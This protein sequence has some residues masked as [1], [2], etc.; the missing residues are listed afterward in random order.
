MILYNDD[1]INGSVEIH[2]LDGVVSA[3]VVLKSGDNSKTLHLEQRTDAWHVASSFDN[4][5]ESGIYTVSLKVTD[6]KG[7]VTTFDNIET[8]E[9]RLDNK[10]NIDFTGSLPDTV[11]VGD[12]VTAFFNANDDVGLEKVTV[13]VNTPG[14]TKEIPLLGSGV[15]K[16]VYSP[17]QEGQYTFTVEVTD[18]RGQTTTKALGNFEV[19]IDTPPKIIDYIIPKQAYKYSNFDILANV[20]DDLG[21]TGIRISFL[22]LGRLL[23]EF[24][25]EL[26]ENGLFKAMCRLTTDG[27]IDWMITATDTA[28]Q[29][30]NQTGQIVSLIPYDD[31]D[32]ECKEI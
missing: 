10:P 7:N 9:Y 19:I 18:T 4:S 25:L 11:Y 29:S 24:T 8:I 16:I 6:T 32:E 5:Y 31:G 30:I 22:K 27:T 1:I 20:T 14:K 17:E 2:D 3:E 21:I 12:N 26:G 13:K 15:F 28:N 23:R